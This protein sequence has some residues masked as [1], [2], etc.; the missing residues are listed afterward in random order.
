MHLSTCT[1]VGMY[2]FTCM[3]V[4]IPQLIFMNNL[5]QNCATL[6]ACF[7]QELYICMYV[8]TFSQTSM[9]VR[10]SATER[11][12]YISIGQCHHHTSESS[13]ISSA[14]FSA[15]GATTLAHVVL[16]AVVVIG[17]CSCCN[18]A[19][20][21]TERERASVYIYIH[22]GRGK[23]QSRSA[24]CK[25]RE[26]HTYTHTCTVGRGRAQAAFWFI[27]WPINLL[28]GG[29][30]DCDDDDDGDGDCD[31]KGVRNGCSCRLGGTASAPTVVVGA[32]NLAFLKNLCWV[33]WLRCLWR[34]HFLL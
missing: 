13:L 4:Y 8:H 11:H 23:E 26:E 10:R 1:Y 32:L 5:A 15:F 24:L 3:Y 27:E 31:S 7:V 33:R 30:C 12:S 14:K 18:C 28:L 22:T 19:N 21:L 20:C 2:I 29:G 17:K 34:W 25:E 9:G 6:L 16:Y